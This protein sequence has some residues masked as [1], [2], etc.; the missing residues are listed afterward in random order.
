MKRSFNEFHSSTSNSNHATTSTIQSELIQLLQS[1]TNTSII[2]QHQKPVFLTKQQRQQIE[3]AKQQQLQHDS[4][5]TTIQPNQSLNN[6]PSVIKSSAIVTQPTQPAQSRD[7]RHSYDKTHVNH[8][9]D[10]NELLDQQYQYELQQYKLYKLG[11]NN[12]QDDK[13]KVRGSQRNKFNFDWNV[14]DDTM[15]SNIPLI[16]NPTNKQSLLRPI[17]N[18]KS[19]RFD[20]NYMSNTKK[21]HWSDVALEQMTDRYWLQFN[22]EFD[23]KIR[24]SNQNNNNDSTGGNTNNIRPLRYWNE[25]Q[26]FDE[27][28]LLRLQQL[29]YHTPTPIQRAGIP[30]GMANN[31]IIGLAETGSGKT[32]AFILPMLHYIHSKCKYMTSIEVRDNLL[33]NGPYSIIMSP[34]RELAQQITTECNKFIDLYNIRTVCIIGGVDIAEQA[35]HMRDGVHCI[36]ATPGRIV[37]LI[38]KNYIVL[39]QCCYIVLDEADRMIDMAFQSQIQLILDSMNQSLKRQTIM[40]T[41][42][43]SSHIQQLATKYLHNPVYITIG[44]R[45]LKAADT[46]E[47]ILVYT[48][49]ESDKQHK[50]LELLRTC[51]PPFI[52]FC[53]LTKSVDE[54]G[55]YLDTHHYSYVSVHAK[56]SQSDR[57]ANMSLFKSGEYDI[58]LCTNV[59]ARGIDVQNVQYVINYEMPQTIEDYTHRIGRTGRAGKNGTAISFINEH[60]TDIMYDLVQMCKLNNIVI[61]KEI[62]KLDSAKYK[63]NKHGEHIKD[64]LD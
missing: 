50:L 51:L 56:L 27:Q 15:K 52:I 38:E 2:Q 35:Q 4:H 49:T 17:N 18:N 42:T 8:K 28:L 63:M 41:A 32:L 43:M 45:R 58:L 19:N 3:H 16:D 21:Q 60:D 5:I 12:T 23:I 39:D 29:D 48:K 44:D 11:I 59:A 10:T 36:I 34:T 53:S 25:C 54:L 47:Q 24:I 57:T 62:D 31:D 30:Y 9:P 20:I 61:P 33:H 55:R 7:I 64:T 37:D 6:K 22:N 26:Q 14:S 1:N 46:V 13:I 40:F